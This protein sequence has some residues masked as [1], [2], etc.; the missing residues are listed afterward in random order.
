MQKYCFEMYENKERG[1]RFLGYKTVLA[2]DTAQAL[3]LVREAVG[4]EVRLAQVYIE[5]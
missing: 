4:E 2:E 3:L 5:Q 1:I